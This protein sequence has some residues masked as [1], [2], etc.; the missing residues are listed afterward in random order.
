MKEKKEKCYKNPQE[1]L[2]LK[3]NERERQNKK[4]SI[5]AKMLKDRHVLE[6]NSI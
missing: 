3:K 1:L 5:A 2:E 6:K 4:S